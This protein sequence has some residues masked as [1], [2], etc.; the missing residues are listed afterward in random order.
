[1]KALF[2][3]LFT[4]LLLSGIAIHKRRTDTTSSMTSQ[5]AHE[6]AMRNLQTG[7]LQFYSRISLNTI[8]DGPLQLCPQELKQ[9]AL[10]NQ[11]VVFARQL[12]RALSYY[13]SK[14]R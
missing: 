2:I 4:I 9:Q 7:H 13:H 8:N 6:Y 3:L 1:M 5:A 12:A 10:A 14:L 11:E